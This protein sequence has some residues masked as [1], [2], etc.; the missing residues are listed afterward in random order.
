M[1]LYITGKAMIW[2]LLVIIMGLIFCFH[3]IKGVM[4]ALGIF[5]NNIE[6]KEE[7]HLSKIINIFVKTLRSCLL[8]AMI[9]FA[10]QYL[11]EK[12]IN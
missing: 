7:N 9:F 12:F 11:L 6:D 2:V 4:S 1:A 8:I 5:N 3:I 10:M